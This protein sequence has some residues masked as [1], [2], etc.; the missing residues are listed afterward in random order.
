MSHV[1]HTHTHTTYSADVPPSRACVG[2]PLMRHMPCHALS[3]HAMQASLCVHGPLCRD[4]AKQRMEERSSWAPCGLELQPSHSKSAAA[5]GCLAASTSQ[6]V[7][8]AKPRCHSNS[9]SASHA[10]SQACTRVPYTQLPRP[11]TSGPSSGSLSAA[12]RR[13]PPD[14]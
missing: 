13:P 6:Q 14:K 2:I 4:A 12:F 9:R 5:P 11:T 8:S 3:C 7:P 10:T 1:Q